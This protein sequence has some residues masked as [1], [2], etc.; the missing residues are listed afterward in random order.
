MSATWVADQQPNTGVLFATAISASFVVAFIAPVGAQTASS[1]QT[2]KPTKIMAAAG[3]AD[4]G[5]RPVTVP[6]SP[7]MFEAS[8]ASTRSPVGHTEAPVPVSGNS[9]NWLQGGG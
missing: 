6:P 1:N 9:M 7:V 3:K 2:A 4:T 5:M 8:Q